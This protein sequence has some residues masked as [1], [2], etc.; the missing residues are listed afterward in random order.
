MAKKVQAYSRPQPAT[1]RLEVKEKDSNFVYRWVNVLKDGNVDMK[2]ELGYSFVTKGDA[3]DAGDSGI[4]GNAVRA[5]ELVLM[6]CSR[7][8][9]EERRKALREYNKV[10]HNRAI[11]QFMTKAQEMDVQVEN[12]TRIRSGSNTEEE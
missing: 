6:R 1:R 10:F 11:E 12:K 8:T 9:Y 3:K 2:K 7:K 4:P 5:G